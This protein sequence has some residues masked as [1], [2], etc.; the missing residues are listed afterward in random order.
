MHLLSEK[1]IQRMVEVVKEYLDSITNEGKRRAEASKEFDVERDR[2]VVAE[3]RP[4]L[5][6]YLSGQLPLSEFK[7][8]NDGLNKRHKLWGF[9]GMK[10][11][12]FFNQL[13]NAAADINELDAQLKAALAVPPT[14]DAARRRMRNFAE[15]VSTV[16]KQFIDRGGSHYSRPKVSSVPYFLSYFWQIQDRHSWPVYYTND[17]NVTT[18]LNLW[19]P[20][21]NLEEDY[22][23]FKTLLQEL[24]EVLPRHIE[25]PVDFYFL[26]HVFWFKGGQP[27]PPSPEG[28][29]T[30]GPPPS[31]P[32]SYVPPIVAVL[33]SIAESNP[34]LAE[35]AR[36]S[37]TTLERALEKHVNAAF[38]ILGYETKLLGQGRGRVPD[39]LAI[40]HDHSYALLWDAKV[41]STAYSIGTD[42]RVIREYVSSQSPGLKRRALRNIYYVVVSSAFAED[43]EDAVRMLKME[44]DVSEVCLLEAKALVAMVDAKLR[45]PLDVTLG[46]DGLQRVFSSSGVIC[47][48]AV[49]EIL[50]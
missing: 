18:D 42:D 37:G 28:G 31:L 30:S 10:G 32:D 47:A 7:S 1:Q 6:S 19:Q 5:D 43:Y 35:A 20:T 14:D 2:L 23:T 9:S 8:R 49:R 24:C 39:G 12:M 46:P 44:T 25:H 50:G 21:D 22:L 48:N 11:Q 38:T 34:G 15:Y 29:G 41:R 45:A 26:E 13:F 40:D 4:L 3:F 27:F 16:G 17:V 36:A 33:P